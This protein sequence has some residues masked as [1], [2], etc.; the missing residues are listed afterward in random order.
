MVR[1]KVALHGL[2]PVYCTW[3]GLSTESTIV[4]SHQRDPLE[5]EK[6]GLDACTLAARCLR[7]DEVRVQT[8]GGPRV[9]WSFMDDA[10]QWILEPQSRRGYSKASVR[11]VSRI[12]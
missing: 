7:I 12:Q 8:G 9:L 11:D 10:L 3:D 5:A 1:P 2:L 4:K 6:A